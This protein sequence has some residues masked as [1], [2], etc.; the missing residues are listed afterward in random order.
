MKRLPAKLHSGEIR[1]SQLMIT[2]LQAATGLGH[3]ALVDIIPETL[4][5]TLM[6]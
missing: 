1:I 2:V 4:A 3:N 5:N 6:L